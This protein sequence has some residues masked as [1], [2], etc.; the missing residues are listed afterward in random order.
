[1]QL[2]FGSGAL[3]GERTDVTIGSSGGNGA[4]PFGVVQDVS[5]DFG[6]TDKELYGQYQWPV[7]IARGQGKITGKARYA[8]ILGNLYSDIFWGLPTATSQLTASQN[9]AA[10]IPSNPGPYTVAVANAGNYFDDLGVVY[11]T[12]T[13]PGSTSGVMQRVASP[14][15]VGQY[16]VN[17]ASG[18]YTFYSG[19]ATL[20]IL[21][22]Y[23]Y[24]IS[25]VGTKVTITNQLLGTTPTW[26]ATFYQMISPGS[27]GTKGLAVRLNA[28]TSSKLMMPTKVDDWEL[29]ELDFSAYADASGTI[30]Y[31]STVE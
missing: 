7:A 23:L 10:I 17:Y 27:S 31:M 11:A 4:H 25:G 6:F 1:M 21:I 30:G 19:D 5:I 13:G 16:S 22:S 14:S 9:E 8:R 12:G 29:S 26:K 28:C 3:W 24:N 18:I 20:A 15:A 2:S